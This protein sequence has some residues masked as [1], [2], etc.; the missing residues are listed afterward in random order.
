MEAA[1]TPTQIGRFKIVEKIGEGAMG[2]VYK[3][4]DT[5]IQRTVA[6]KTIR[7]DVERG[8]EKYTEVC[9]R[10][11]NEARISATLIHPNIVTLFDLGEHEGTPFLAMEY[12]EGRTLSKRMSQTPAPDTREIVEY[13][14]QTAA[15][16]DF[17]HEKGIVHRD[18]KPGNIMIDTSGR[19]KVMDF[20]IAK[21]TDQSMTRT[22]TFVGTPSYISPEQASERKIDY[23][24]DIFSLGVMAY[25]LF[26]GE[27]P[28]QGST[29]PNLLYKIVFEN[30]A[31]PRNLA[32]WG[33]TIQ[34]WDRV[35]SKV[36]AKD[37]EKRFQRASEFVVSLRLHFLQESQP[38][39]AASQP[40]A[41][42]TSDTA[43]LA[44]SGS[45]AIKS[46]I[47]LAIHEHVL[48]ETKR[49]M[50]NVAAARRVSTAVEPAAAMQASRFDDT[51]VSS[52]SK[53][54]SLLLLLVLIGGV[55]FL[56]FR[57]LWPVDAGPGGGDLTEYMIQVDSQPQGAEIQIDGQPTGLVTPE[58]VKITGKRDEAHTITLRAPCYKELT[59]TFQLGENTPVR[60]APALVAAGV[61]ITV[62]T[63]PTGAMVSV[64]GKKIQASPATIELPCDKKHVI[65]AGLQ[66][67][68]TASQEVDPAGAASPL[69]LVLQPRGEP[70]TLEIIA[71]YGYQVFS[72]SS[73]VANG[74]GR[75]TIRLDPGG[76]KIRVVNKE[77]LLN[78]SQTVMIES[79][80]TS[81]IE[82]PA[83]GWFT[84]IGASPENCEIC[85]DGKQ[86]CDYPPIRNKYIAPGEHTITFRWQDGRTKTIVRTVMPGQAVE[87]IFEKP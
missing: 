25:E 42:S 7:L 27:K 32:Q 78:L 1:S 51:T 8:T 39:K 68:H 31:R 77:Y 45:G 56:L 26:T 83:L 19:I 66:G 30:P 55:A 24:S 34:Q 47:P 28:F 84:S 29:I 49:G 12:V 9:Q 11:Y 37:P 76:H 13:L 4:H 63:E 18:V 69:V 50:Q 75:D 71:T 21:I 38:I 52:R 65:T 87:A 86:F 72:G 17:A 67:Y 41:S 10:F 79:G 36:L 44:T 73:F 33:V 2:T 20:G 70:G 40:L 23:R 48:E 6:I 5:L 43:K 14:A 74:S 58:P 60:I 81:T 82:L 3:A 64:D 62:Q 61:R 16:L 57:Y 35:F 53:A 15:A 46:D 59:D 80:R 54:L 22:G 85:V